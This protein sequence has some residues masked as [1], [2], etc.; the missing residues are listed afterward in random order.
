MKLKDWQKLLVPEF[1]IDAIAIEDRMVRVFGF[2]KKKKIIDK[3][4]SFSLPEGVIQEGILKKPKEL[5]SFFVS[6]R[7]KLW[8]EQ[9]NIW[10]VLSLP[11]ANFYTNILS[12]P[13]LDPERFREAVAF[14]AQVH[15]PLPLEEAYFDWEDWG[16]AEK[17]DEKEVFIALGIKKQ[18]DTYLKI[19]SNSGFKIVAVE[20]FALSL[21]RFIYQFGR[22]Q[23]PVLAIDLRQEGIEFILI[24][25]QKLIFFDFDS[26]PEIFGKKIPTRITVDLLKEHLAKEI[27]MLLNFYSLKR[28]RDLKYFFL[29]GKPEPIVKILRKEVQESYHLVPLS[30]KLPS[31]LAKTDSSWQGVIGGALRGLLPRRQDTIVSLAPVGTEQDY[32]QIHLFS[33]VSLWLKALITVVII[34][35]T[36]LG[37]VNKLFFSRLVRDYQNSVSTSVEASAKQKDSQLTK[38][39]KQFNDLVTQVSVVRQ[40]SR[41]WHKDT[42]TIFS[43]AHSSSVIVK[44]VLVSASPANNITILG[45]A[46]SKNAVIQ[47]KTSLDQSQLFSQI[48]LPLDALIETPSGVTFSLSLKL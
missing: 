18:V 30:L 42:A 4:E 39:M 38:E 17:E 33:I 28:R 5:Q 3:I 47:F 41:D 32:Y 36:V 46:P 1:T 9:K 14:N 43:A 7:Q 24:E 21:A 16:L 20:P 8:A 27:P 2:N 15:I 11:S 13:E 48:N 40:Y 31:Y 45:V 25:G 10:V 23:A 22:Q 29:G 19:L 37:G 12:I 34:L 26:W 44:R 35:M 6:L